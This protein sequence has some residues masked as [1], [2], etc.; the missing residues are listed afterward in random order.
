MIARLSR[1][2]E[3]LVGL[4]LALMATLVIYQV[5]ARYAF[6]QPPSW[7]EEMARFLQVWLVMLAAPVCLRRG[8]HLA[9]DYVGPRLGAPGRRLLRG[10]VYGLVAAF[11]AVLTVYGIRL[12]SI[13]ALQTSPALGISMLWPYLAVPVGGGLMTIESLRLMAHTGV[14]SSAR[15][16]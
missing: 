4:I 14:E 1:F 6:N 13:A 15:I 5:I 3:V 9:V 8:M 7:T 10:A 16:E 2:A 12:L 11:S